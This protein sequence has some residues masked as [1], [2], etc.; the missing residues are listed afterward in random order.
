MDNF[1]NF[2]YYNNSFSYVKVIMKN[3]NNNMEELVM[4]DI[5]N[6]MVRDMDSNNIY[7][8]LIV[9]S[10]FEKKLNSLNKA[11]KDDLLNNLYSCY[12][13]P[14]FLNYMN[15]EKDMVKF[16]FNSLN[17]KIVSLSS[18]YGLF[19]ENQNVF[20]ENIKKSK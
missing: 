12:I 3:L 4:R 17:N 18:F 7:E 10:L 19:G 5:F 15:D 16:F 14:M 20:L 11:Q 13:K 8:M 9:S 1:E 2:D 6:E